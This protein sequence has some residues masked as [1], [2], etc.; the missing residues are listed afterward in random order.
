[1]ELQGRRPAHRRDTEWEIIGRAYTTNMGKN[2]Y[3]RVRRVDQPEIT[4]IRA[5]SAHQRISVTRT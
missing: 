3:V 1:M 4:E 2:A 5:W